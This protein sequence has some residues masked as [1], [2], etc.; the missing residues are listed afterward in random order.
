[1]S[2][3]FKE[4]YLSKK[5][6]AYDDESDAAYHRKKPKHKVK[7][8]NHKHAYETCVI[9]DK[10]HPDMIHL[11]KRCSV[12]GKIDR[13][14]S[15]IN[16]KMKRKFPHVTYNSIMFNEAKD[17]FESELEECIQWCKSHYPVYEMDQ[18][19]KWRDKYV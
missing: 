15:P 5:Y 6:A 1:M 16:N 9:I 14:T 12:C 2:F 13:Y 19:D 18:Y 10:T 4:E 7:K 3:N 17:G 11:V 8:S